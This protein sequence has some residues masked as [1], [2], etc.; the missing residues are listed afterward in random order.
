MTPEPIAIMV[1]DYFGDKLN[2]SRPVLTQ[3][4]QDQ[5]FPYT[6]S[7]LLDLKPRKVKALGPYADESNA[8]I[9]KTSSSRGKEF[10]QSVL[11]FRNVTQKLHSK[12]TAFRVLF[13]RLNPYDLYLKR[14]IFISR[15]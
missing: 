14:N 2:H 7:S 4:C 12:R 10:R 9:L 6:H 1:S 8:S 3:K 11:P 13:I 15:P 5:R